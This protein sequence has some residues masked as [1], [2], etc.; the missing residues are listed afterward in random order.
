VY[1]RPSPAAPEWDVGR[2]SVEV[3]CEEAGAYRAWR[4]PTAVDDDR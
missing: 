4:D 3:T 1:Y 2:W